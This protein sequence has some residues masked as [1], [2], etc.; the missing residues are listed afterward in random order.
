M[1][2]FTLS[3]LLFTSSLFLCVLMCNVTRVVAAIERYV[4]SSRN[5]NNFSKSNGSSAVEK[6]PDYKNN[7]VCPSDVPEIPPE[8]LV[9]QLG[10]SHKGF[11]R[12]V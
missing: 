6:S 12:N 2:D 10:T 7:K 5:I 11:G 3:M 9:P 8:V 4:D 1:I